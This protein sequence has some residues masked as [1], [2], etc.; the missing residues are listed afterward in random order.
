MAEKVEEKNSGRVKLKQRL[1]GKV[2]RRRGKVVCYNNY[3]QVSGYS[4]WRI[5]EANQK[6]GRRIARM[7]IQSH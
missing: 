3:I 7:F 1:E 6:R 4:N 5:L 2:T